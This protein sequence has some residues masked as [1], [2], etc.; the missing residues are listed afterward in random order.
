M[1]DFSKFLIVEVKFSFEMFLSLCLTVYFQLF[2]YSFSLGQ[3]SAL[4]ISLFV[5]ALVVLSTM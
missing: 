3:T 1:V 5:L 4:F 2:L